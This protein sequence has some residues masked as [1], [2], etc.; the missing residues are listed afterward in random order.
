MTQRNTEW[1]EERNRENDSFLEKNQIQHYQKLRSKIIV[2]IRIRSNAILIGTFQLLVPV[3]KC[4]VFV[5]VY[6][7]LLN[8]FLS[9]LV[10]CAQP[11]SFLVVIR[12]T[13]VKSDRFWL[14][15]H[16][17]SGLSLWFMEEYEVQLG[18]PGT[19]SP[20][21]SKIR[22]RGYSSQDPGK[23]RPRD[24]EPENGHV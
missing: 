20:L 22:K 24:K 13:L 2:K 15:D 6:W 11:S 19:S 3:F 18:L 8:K 16:F 7:V 23:G 17:W 12:H 5:V 9:G 21:E 4:F 10:V 1:K 14:F